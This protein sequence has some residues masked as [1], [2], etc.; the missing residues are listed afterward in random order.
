MNKEKIPYR[1]FFLR[2]AIT[3]V[4]VGVAVLAGMAMFKSRYLIM[5]D[6]QQERCLPNYSIYLVDLKDKEL[7]KGKPYAFKAKGIMPWLDNIHEKARKLKDHYKDGRVLLKVVDAIEGDKIKVGENTLWINGKV[8]PA[9][10]LILA[11]TLQLP[12][13]TFVRDITVKR[14]E[15]WFFGRTNNSFD[16]RYWG[17]VVQD[18]IVGRAYPI[19]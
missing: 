3:S 5:Y 15:Y 2:A 12:K 16:S 11:P 7:V 8:H 9:G 18:Q 17:P 1:Q 4:V 19:L 10:G 6:P 14:G 13:S